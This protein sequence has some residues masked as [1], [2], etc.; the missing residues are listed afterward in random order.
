MKLRVTAITLALVALLTLFVGCAKLSSAEAPPP[1]ATPLQA[2]AALTSA[3]E[4]PTPT[5]TPTSAATEYILNDPLDD[6]TV[7][8]ALWAFDSGNIG[9]GESIISVS[10]SG[11]QLLTV[12]KLQQDF[13]NTYASGITNPLGKHVDYLALYTL[14]AGKYT[15][16]KQTDIYDKFSPAINDTL[17]SCDLDGVAWSADESLALIGVGWRNASAYLRTNRSDIY[18]ADFFAGSIENLTGDDALRESLSEGGSH[19]ALPQWIDDG[20]IRYVHYELSE[21]N[22]FSASLIRMDL[23]TGSQSILAALS[24]DGRLTCIY[25]YA[26]FGNTVYFVNDGLALENTGFFKARLD[27]GG[28]PP[29]QLLDFMSIRENNLHPYASAFLSVKI[30]RDGRWAILTESDRRLFSRDIPMADYPELPQPN[31]A[32]AVSILTGREWIP[33]HN[34]FLYDLREDRLA[35]PF[36]AEALRPDKCIVV[37]AVFAPDGKS[38][39]CAALGDGGVW[40]TDSFFTETALYQIKLADGSFDANRIFKMDIEIGASPPEVLEWLDNNSILI[41]SFYGSVPTS[42]VQIATPAAFRRFAK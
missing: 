29:T 39:I 3:P 7:A 27:G 36:S 24:A 9:D 4:T 37:G 6:K 1:T 13:G 5:P 19:N 12:Y 41:R 14:R 35:A 26:V 16:T 38:L 22:S 25:D 2:A 21:D 11:K 32:S 8:T 34:V 17:A 42:S 23:N 30:S 10:P 15:R 33:C 31:P 28:A 20:S 18:L 40:L